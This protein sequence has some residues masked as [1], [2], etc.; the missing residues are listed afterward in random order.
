[1][2]INNIHLKDVNSYKV[3]FND[4]YSGISSTTYIGDMSFLKM[5]QL[6]DNCYFCISNT[7]DKFQTNRI[8][9]DVKY[10][11]ETDN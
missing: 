6:L 5:R 11:K 7:K 8:D 10:V 2:P 1:M 4:S 3:D 9:L